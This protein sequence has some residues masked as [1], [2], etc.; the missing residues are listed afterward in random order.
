MS[1]TRGRPRQFDEQKV[2]QAILQ[3]FWE[4]GFAAT[5]LD[6]LSKATGLVRPSLYGAF[7]SKTDMYLIALDTFL[8]KLTDVRAALAATDTPQE[9]LETFLRCMTD[10]YF[11][12]GSEQQLGCFLVGTALTEAPNNPIIREALAQRMARFDQMLEMV[13]RAKAPNADP[14]KIR[15]AVEQGTAIMHSIA[16][17]ARSGEPQINLTTF[18][19]ASAQIIANLLKD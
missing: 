16:V 2:K 7:G 15:L 1:K 13:L 9:A 17:R 12:Q 3:T 14:A 11:D 5:S 10:V 8:E 6:D 18:A 19:Q 4:Q